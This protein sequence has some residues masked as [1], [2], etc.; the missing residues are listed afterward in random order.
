MNLCQK[1]PVLTQII[2]MLEASENKVM[3]WVFGK[4]VTSLFLIFLFI[5][6]SSKEVSV[7]SN[8]SQGSIESQS[9]EPQSKEVLLEV[10]EKS[11]GM[12]H[13]KGTLLLIR[14]YSTGE[15]E[16]ENFVASEFSPSQED[17][18]SKTEARKVKL[19][20]EVVQEIKTLIESS[21]FINAKTFYSPTI[22]FSDVLTTV[23]IKY[24]NLERQIVLKETDTSLHLEKKDKEYP[25]SVMTLLKLIDD[26]RSK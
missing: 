2:Y 21:D 26:L 14:L 18:D 25:R 12:V 20:K 11:E 22:F 4:A 5:G 8:I 16:F 24:Q 19:E 6:C 1:R 15:A 9:V 7:I 23:T 17:I 10:Y 13:P 3:N